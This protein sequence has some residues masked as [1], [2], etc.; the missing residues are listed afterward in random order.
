M[1]TAGN[2]PATLTA[3][4]YAWS[5]HVLRASGAQGK[6]VLECESTAA[7]GTHVIIL[8]EVPASHHEKLAEIAYYSYWG[9]RVTMSCKMTAKTEWPIEEPDQGE[10][11][12]KPPDNPPK[13][14]HQYAHKITRANQFM[15]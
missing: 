15:V 11:P 2:L 3:A 5:K 12:P 13:K 7:G 14:Q 1:E 9:A 8:N 6:S 4:S 10:A